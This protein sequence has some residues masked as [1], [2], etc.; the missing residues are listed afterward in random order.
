VDE[1]HAGG[2]SHRW[3]FLAIP[4]TLL[5]AKAMHRHMPPHEGGHGSWAGRRGHHGWGRWAG[6]EGDGTP[7][8]RLPQRVESML[9]TWHERAHQ[10]VDSDE[11]PSADAKGN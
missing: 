9:N 3:L 11:S 2:S 1:K 10:A 5:M 7:D 4:A 6:A 8:F